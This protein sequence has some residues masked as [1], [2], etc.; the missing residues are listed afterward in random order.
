MQRIDKGETRAVHHVGCESPFSTSFTK[1]FP[2]STRAAVWG[3]K[4]RYVSNITALFPEDD[5]LFIES[6]RIVSHA[7]DFSG[8]SV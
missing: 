8:A 5:N 3:T 4:I 1:P 6:R 2:I 7:Y